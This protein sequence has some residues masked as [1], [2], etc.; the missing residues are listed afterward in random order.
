MSL[1]Y[2]HFQTLKNTA[3]PA[4]GFK[5]IVIFPINPENLIPPKGHANRLLNG[6]MDC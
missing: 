2:K 4:A 1:F 6:L 3:V 5:K